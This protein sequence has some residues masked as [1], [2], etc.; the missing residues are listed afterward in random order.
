MR[1]PYFLALSLTL[2]SLTGFAN[3]PTDIMQNSTYQ[4]GDIII[5]QVWAR[6]MPPTAPA[7]AVYFQLENTGDTPTRLLSAQSG[8]SEKTELHTHIKTADGLMRMEQV[9]QV[10]I[11]AKGKLAFKPG[12]YHVMLL[13]LKQPLVA[14]SHFPL[15]LTFESGSTVKLEVPVLES[16]PQANQGTQT[17]HGHMHHH[18]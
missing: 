5:N 8:I 18:H 11:P 16:A 6:A 9:F 3:D 12:S 2:V 13:Q 15:E 10:E 7:G 1:I 14:G 17:E 4:A